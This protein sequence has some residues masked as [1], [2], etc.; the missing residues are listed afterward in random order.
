MGLLT[1]RQLK[2]LACLQLNEEGRIVSV[3]LKSN[4][5]TILNVAYFFGKGI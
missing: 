2:Q 4:D 5:Q 1:N 3:K